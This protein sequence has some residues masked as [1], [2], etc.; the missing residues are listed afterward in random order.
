MDAIRENTG[1]DMAIEAVGAGP[2][3]KLTRAKDN[4]EA[5]ALVSESLED[6]LPGDIISRTS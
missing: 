3:V 4:N 6:I 1:A 5:L 2:A